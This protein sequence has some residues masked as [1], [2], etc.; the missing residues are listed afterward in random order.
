M[1]KANL[2]DCKTEASTIAYLFILVM[3]SK[4]TITRNINVFEELNI[5]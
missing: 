4:S 5:N 1:P 3:A 2:I